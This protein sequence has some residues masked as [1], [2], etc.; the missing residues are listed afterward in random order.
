VR[1]IR[2]TDP[3][4]YHDATRS[5]DLVHEYERLRAETDVLWHRLGELG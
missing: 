3:E 4:L 2:F 5:K 1:G